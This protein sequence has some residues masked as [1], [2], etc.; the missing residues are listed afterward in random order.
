MLGAPAS[1][2]PHRVANVDY[3][4]LACH[5]ASRPVISSKF[6]LLGSNLLA[7]Y[8]LF[9]FGIRLSAFLMERTV[10][11]PRG[12]S[13]GEQLPAF[14]TNSPYS[15]L[16]PEAGLETHV[17][18]VSNQPKGTVSSPGHCVPLNQYMACTEGLA[19]QFEGFLGSQYALPLS[20]I[21]YHDLMSLR[22]YHGQLRKLPVRRRTNSLLPHVSHRFVPKPKRKTS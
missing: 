3:L 16:Y 6:T 2:Q 17:C 8:E 18:G 15:E 22:Y 21:L 5:I 7:T 13:N 11:L 1:W 14:P 20:S 4:A 12:A 19:V 9:G 10:T